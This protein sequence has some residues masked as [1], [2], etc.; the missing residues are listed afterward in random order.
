MGRNSTV[1]HAKCVARVD[2]ENDTIMFRQAELLGPNP[3]EAM[4]KSVCR[5]I[6]SVVYERLRR[7]AAAHLRG[8]RRAHAL[9]PVDL[10]SEVYIRLAD[11]RLEFADQAH[12]FAIASRTMYQILVDN[13]R[14][15]LTAKRGA[16]EVPVEF[17]EPH[18]AAA[19]PRELVA[20]GDALNDLVTFERRIATAISLR[21]F[22]GLTQGEIATMCHIHPNTVSRDLNRGKVWLRNHLNS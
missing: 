15:Q 16:G 14:K 19:R 21:Y 10:I 22:F 2:I 1:N 6:N 5:E 7:L 9:D 4:T 8:D 13:A 18:V 11:D 17:E 3:S 12:F 20:L